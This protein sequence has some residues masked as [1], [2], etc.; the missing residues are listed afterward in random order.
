MVVCSLMSAGIYRV[1]SGEAFAIGLLPEVGTWE[2]RDSLGAKPSQTLTYLLRQLFNYFYFYWLFLK[3]VP[4]YQ[5][6]TGHPAPL[7]ALEEQDC[8]RQKQP[9]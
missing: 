6:A 7:M 3:M 2:T 9:L 5:S 8:G 1:T 4:F